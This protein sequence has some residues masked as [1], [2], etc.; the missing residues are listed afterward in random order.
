MELFCFPGENTRVNIIFEGAAEMAEDEQIIK[1]QPE[2]VKKGAY[3]FI[4][5]NPCKLEICEVLPKATANGNKRLHIKGPHVFT[6]KHYEDTLN[7]SAGFHGIDV[8]VTTKAQYS[9]MDVDS[10]TGFLSLLTDSGD[11]KEDVGLV[12]NDEDGSFDELGIEVIGK[13]DAGESLKLTVLS[14]LGKD[15]VVA[16][17]VDTG[18]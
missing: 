7:L 10:E 4:R 2:A 9:L 14:L 13:F 15:V 12:K 17:D 8:P 18:A 11:C 1:V 16:C 6:G 3:C 5:G